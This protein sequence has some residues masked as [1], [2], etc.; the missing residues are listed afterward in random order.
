MTTERAQVSKL[1]KEWVMAEVDM[2][3]D[4]LLPPEASVRT[5]ARELYAQ[6]RDLPLL[7]PHGHV[8]PALLADDE[9]FPDPAWLFIIPD[10]YVHRMLHS[11]RIPHEELGLVDVDG[12]QRETDSRRVWKRLC[13][14]WHLFSGTP[15]KIWLEMELA[16]VFGITTRLA[17][18][19][20]DHVYDEL[21]ERLAQPEYRPRAL[22]ERFNIEVLATTDDATDRLET[23]Q[24][25]RDDAWTGKVIPTYRPDKVLDPDQPTFHAS[26]KLLGEVTGQDTMSYIGYLTALRQRREHFRRMG[27]TATDH[28]HPSAYTVELSETDAEKLFR[29]VTEGEYDATD[30]EQFRGHMLMQMAKMSLEDGLVMQLHPGSVRNHDRR[31]LD[32]YGLDKGADIP[33]P[34][35]YVNHLKPLLNKYGNEPGFTFV[36]FTLDEAAYS[37]ELAPLAGYYPAMQ[38]GPA[39]WFYDSPHGIRRYRELVTE[40]AGFYNTA[41]FNDDTRAFASIPVRHDVARR[42]DCGYLAQLV[43]EHRM[44][45]DEAHEVAHALAYGRAKEVYRL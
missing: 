8:D 45:L 17:A 22:F 12:E 2:H 32:R 13:E 19:T 26:L 3:D 9:P 15:S 10:H 18:D 33:G 30:A 41:G 14:N 38:L 42:I 27:A 24:R 7:C 11:A 40:T 4:R 23:H 29:R 16:E 44:A 35:D 1:G 20:A 37:R 21:L 28:G 36:A 34:T 43:I 5:V 25:I 39:W 31:L 6:V